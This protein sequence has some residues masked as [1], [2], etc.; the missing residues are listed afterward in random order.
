[1]LI[2]ATNHLV[3]EWKK[4]GCRRAVGLESVLGAGQWKAAKFWEQKAL[5]NFDY[6]REKGDGAIT[7]VKF[8]GFSGFEEGDDECRLPDGWNISVSVRED[9]EVVEIVDA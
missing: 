4:G 7:G 2:Q 8:Y 1:M 6:G 5:Q 9:D 3:C